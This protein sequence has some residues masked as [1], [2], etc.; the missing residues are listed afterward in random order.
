M[1]NFV[2]VFNKKMLGLAVFVLVIFSSLAYSQDAAET[3]DVCPKGRIGYGIFKP[4]DTDQ[5]SLIEAEIKIKCKKGEGYSS[6]V[7]AKANAS[8]KL[9]I[10]TKNIAGQVISTTPAGESKADFT[11]LS[12]RTTT[13]K[14]GFL[15]EGT[16]LGYGVGIYTIAPSDPNVDDGLGAFAQVV[17]GKLFSKN[18]TA[19]LGITYG[20]YGDIHSSARG[21]T[22]NVN[23]MF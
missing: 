18:I 14:K 15:G 16:M 6:I 8:A 3:K 19:Q 13:V 5:G 9:V 22:A 10:E 12:Y 1:K 11:F 4:L 7:I 2:C 17:V 20:L 23:L 21:I